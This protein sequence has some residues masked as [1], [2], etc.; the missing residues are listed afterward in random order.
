MTSGIVVFLT[1][2]TFVAYRFFTFKQNAIN[3]LAT[4]GEIVAA[5]S[6]AALAFED[7]KDATETLQ[8]LKADKHIVAA[9]LYD[10]SGKVFAKYPDTISAYN[11]PFRPGA[12]GYAYVGTFLE[13]YQQVI[14]GNIWV[15]TL[16]IRSDLTVV[17]ETFIKYIIVALF[18]FGMAVFIAYLLSRRLQKKVSEPILA[19]SRTAGT[20]SQMKNYSVRATKYEND[21]LGLL[22][23]SFNDML[24][25]IER[26]NEEITSFTHALEAKVNQRTAELEKANLE[27]KLQTQF[28]EAIID[29]SVDV[30][31]V[32]DKQLN[33]VLLN[34]YGRD[35]YGVSAE[36]VLGKNIL[37][38]F[39]ETEH[40]QMYKDLKK[41]FEGEMIHNPYYKSQISNSI[42]E[43]F[44]IPLLDSNN[45]VYNVLVIGHDITAIIESNEKL[46]DLNLSLEHS[47]RDLEQFAYIA[48]HD[49]QE[50]LRKIQIFSSHLERKLDDKDAT[51]KNLSKIISSASRMSDLINGVLN[52][53]R[54]ANDKQEYTIV[55]LQKVIQNILSD[56]ELLIEEKLAEIEIRELPEIMGN[57]LQLNQL[58]S[59]LLSNSL[60]FT[61]NRPHI[62]IS[63]SIIAGRDV[64]PFKAIN[65]KTNYALIIFEDDGIGFAQE[66]AHNVF[67]VF[68]RLHSKEEYPGTGIGLALCK[69]IVDN[70]NGHISVS[71]TL[72][73][74]TSFS[75]YLPLERTIFSSAVQMQNV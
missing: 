26:Q 66:Y 61:K 51:R 71:S 1:C 56:F 47:N 20:I 30:I 18:V 9:C 72:G 17:Y 14:Q 34:K 65:E 42:L 31:A 27:L 35:I 10:T 45:E 7:Q 22:T 75:I 50:P 16:Y 21:E 52:Y 67:S 69:K 13:G 12:P 46:K 36:E 63:S 70:H 38:V 33:Y 15:G 53:S 23:D 64:L 19:L 41:A 25:Q 29:S 32:F 37:T 5:N 73:E 28:A 49:L 6:T 62:C 44:F 43:N 40:S 55:D 11:I 2:L 4:V 48:S 54:L 8:A 74:G 58:F 57:E 3:Q 59:N 24:D 68:Q 39:P 60:K